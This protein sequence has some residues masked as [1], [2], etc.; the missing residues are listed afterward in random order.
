V[1]CILSAQVRLAFLE[2]IGNWMLTLRE[3][4]DHEP[5]LLPYVLSGICDESPAVVQ[6]ALQ[7]LDQLGQQYEQEHEAELADMLRFA[8]RLECGAEAQLMQAGGLRYAGSWDALQQQAR[9]TVAGAAVRALGSAAQKDQAPSTPT[10]ASV[11]AQQEAVQ[12]FTLP[13]PFQQRARL[14]SRLLVRGNLS[15]LLPALCRELSSW[16]SCPRA[17]SARLLLV[18]LLLVE[19]AAEQHLQVGAHVCCS[20]WLSR[21]TLELRR[22]WA[23]RGAGRQAN[24]LAQC[25]RIRHPMSPK[26]TA[27]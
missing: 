18:S 16:Q 9:G 5:R 14:G 27:V 12:G 3:R 19:S 20:A 17:M 23:A 7:L 15:S 24:H 21:H 6:A 10:A 13:G 2:C 1:S 25:H 4:R 26:P 11:G 8:D 22:M